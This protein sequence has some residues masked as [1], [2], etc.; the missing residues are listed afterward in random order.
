MARRD[1]D[2]GE[3]AA[4]VSARRVCKA[5]PG[6]GP[7]IRVGFKDLKSGTRAVKLEPVRAETIAC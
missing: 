3:R 4:F 1:T 6:R 2:C 7:G 5:D